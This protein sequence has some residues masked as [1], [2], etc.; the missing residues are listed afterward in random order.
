M[1]EDKQGNIK[2]KHLFPSLWA[3]IPCSNQSKLFSFSCQHPHI[4]RDLTSV[5][6]II[7]ICIYMIFNVAF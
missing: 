6:Y 2:Q 4:E 3:P 7:H 5:I 1:D